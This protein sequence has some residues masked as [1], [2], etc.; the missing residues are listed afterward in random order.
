MKENEQKNVSQRENTLEDSK[1]DDT[2][3]LVI[4][5]LCLSK[6]DFALKDISFEVPGGYITGL[7]GKNGSGKTT[8]MKAVCNVYT[9]QSG[10]I[11]VAGLDHEKDEAVVKQRIG[12]VMP[13]FTFFED[14]SLI[15]N[16]ELL[17][18]LY[19]NFSMERFIDYLIKFE[20]KKE[21]NC[22]SHLVK[23]LSTG[24]RVRF[25]LAFAL[26]H[27]PELLLLDEPTANLDPAFR[28][29]LL[30]DLQEV[31]EDGKKGVL[32]STHLTADLDK[33]GDYIVLMDKGR[34]LACQTKE[35]LADSY[36]GQDVAGILLLA[37]KEDEKKVTEQSEQKGREKPEKTEKEQTGGRRV[38]IKEKVG[39]KSVV[40]TIENNPLYPLEERIWK[41]NRDNRNN[42]YLPLIGYVVVTCFLWLISAPLQSNLIFYTGYF[43]SFIMVFHTQLGYSSCHC[44][45]GD[46]CLYQFAGYLPVTREHFLS[47]YRRRRKNGAL[48]FA[49]IQAILF[50][51]LLEEMISLPVQ[52]SPVRVVLAAS[53]I[54]IYPAVAA[55]AETRFM[56]KMLK[57]WESG[58]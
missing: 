38:K 21:K 41:E 57:L 18:P 24:Q 4:N 17:G 56:K 50:I 2:N 30:E 3:V 49:G 31:I 33:I 47:L 13:E 35:E 5:H 19:E 39:D 52:I 22:T 11:S 42:Y 46:N 1:T 9:K 7:V 8:L 15:A 23:S 12:L 16:G 27:Q 34:I 14:K 55:F 43:I 40:H 58:D 28:V 29:K 20:L 6:G 44:V 26:A 51:L 37:V 53:T 36:P 10:R 32:M 48:C 25:Q 45:I 54:L